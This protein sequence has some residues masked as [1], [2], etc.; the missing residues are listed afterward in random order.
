MNA[1]HVCI[2]HFQ[3]YRVKCASPQIFAAMNI[4]S[5]TTLYQCVEYDHDSYLVFM[6]TI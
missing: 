6:I 4:G 3:S 2:L 5:T 1:S